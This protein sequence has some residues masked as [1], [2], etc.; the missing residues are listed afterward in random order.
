MAEVII[1]TTNTCPHCVRA[2]MLLQKKNAEYKEVDASDPDVREDMIKKAN[3]RRTVPQIFIND[4]PVGGA[5]DLFELESK[6]ELDGLLA[7]ANQ[8]PGDKSREL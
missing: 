7:E 8:N 3:G 6:G 4:K 1:Y 5:D 2:K